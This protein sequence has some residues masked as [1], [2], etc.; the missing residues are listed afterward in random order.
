MRTIAEHSSTATLTT[1]REESTT[2]ILAR[3]R[4][5]VANTGVHAP[6]GVAAP[7]APSPTTKS[8]RTAQPSRASHENAPGDLLRLYLTDVGGTSLLNESDEL[9]AARHLAQARFHY[10]RS[11]LSCDFVLQGVTEIVEKI[12]AGN[13]RLDR[14]LNLWVVDHAK[15]QELERRLRP[16]LVALRRIL[17]RNGRDFRRAMNRQL[18]YEQR[19]LAR[20]NLA[21]RRAEGARLVEQLEMRLPCL[22]PLLM[23]LLEVCREMLMLQD[24]RE[25]RGGMDPQRDATQRRD[26][27]RLMWLTRET[28]GA[29]ARRLRR[30]LEYRRQYLAARQTLTVSNLRLVVSLAKHYQP[31]GLSL[32][33]LI[34][35]GNIGLLRAIDKFEHRRGHKFSTYAVW[36]IRQSITRALADQGR[37]V[38]VPFHLQAPLKQVREAAHAYLIEHGR[39]PAAEELAALCGLPVS[40]TRHLARLSQAPLSLDQPAENSQGRSLGEMLADS[41]PHD[42]I[43]QVNAQAIQQVVADALQALGNREREVVQLRYGLHDGHSRSLM[44]V[45]QLLSLSRETVRQIEKRAFGRLRSLPEFA[46]L[47]QQLMS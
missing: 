16:N 36:W 21:V 30:T 46:P 11:L 45:G 22:N 25:L 4:R 24:E 17:G 34:Q 38:R 35:E 13:L 10:Q 26:L 5:R 31:W 44:E 39:E 23:R 33:D 6:H 19:R 42:P 7:H 28:P 47:A 12:L 41:R 29:L 15:R 14:T 43:E 27:R 1:G 32:P 40:E 20:E 18:P 9:S 37:I 2:G 3:R 8:V